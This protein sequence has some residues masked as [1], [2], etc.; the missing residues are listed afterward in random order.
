MVLIKEFE[1]DLKYI[2]S[3]DILKLYTMWRSDLFYTFQHLYN[4]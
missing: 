4:W 3:D 1:T 2:C